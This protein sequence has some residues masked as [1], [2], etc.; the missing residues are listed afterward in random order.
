MNPLATPFTFAAAGAGTAKSATASATSTP[1][2]EEQSTS[3]DTITPNVQLNDQKGDAHAI[4][5][6]DNEIAALRKSNKSLTVRLL[7]LEQETPEEQEARKLRAKNAEIKALKVFFE[8]ANS[9]TDIIKRRRT[10]REKEL[11]HVQAEV[12]FLQPRVP[13]AIKEAKQK[14]KKGKQAAA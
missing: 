7:E 2:I 10:E 6:K 12:A 1:S 5:A 3:A 8:R 14:G 11:R 4:Q 13:F 9:R